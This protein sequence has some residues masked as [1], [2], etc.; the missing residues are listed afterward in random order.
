MCGNGSRS[1]YTRPT[2]HHKKDVR[3]TKTFKIVNYKFGLIL[4]ML[5]RDPFFNFGSEIYISSWIIS[6][7]CQEGTDVINN[8]RSPFFK[9]NTCH[10]ATRAKSNSRNNVFQKYLKELIVQ[11][12]VLFGIDLTWDTSLKTSTFNV[13]YKCRSDCLLF[14]CD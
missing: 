4:Y 8:L 11:I 6:T 14:S 3:W 10:A 1:Y 13:Y 7:T 2:V 9:F 5:I 12:W